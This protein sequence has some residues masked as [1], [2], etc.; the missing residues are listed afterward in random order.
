MSSWITVK[1]LQ[2]VLRW[3]LLSTVIIAIGLAML[4]DLQ[5]AFSAFLGGMVSVVASAA[6]AIIVSR[7]K[8]YTAGGTIRTALRAEAVKIILTI[9]LLWT[10]FKFYNEL[11]A[12]IFIGTFIIV[13]LMHSMALLVSDRSSKAQKLDNT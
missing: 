12:P 10:V 3:Q 9:L 4:L 7:H 8:G 1:P 11:N 5:D 13:V 2:I 6:F